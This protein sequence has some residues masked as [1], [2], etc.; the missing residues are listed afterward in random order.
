VGRFDK[1]KA[2]SRERWERR[3]LSK[4]RSK[5]STGHSDQYMYENVIRE[6]EKVIKVRKVV[7]NIIFRT[8]YLVT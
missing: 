4:V 2:L 1:K 5:T 3:G 8:I 6:A 7:V